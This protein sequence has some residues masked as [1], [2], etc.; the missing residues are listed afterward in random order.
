MALS[1]IN[2]GNQDDPKDLAMQSLASEGKE[3]SSTGAGISSK[4][5]DLFKRSHLIQR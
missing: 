5:K 3:M 2:Y 4:E 1:P